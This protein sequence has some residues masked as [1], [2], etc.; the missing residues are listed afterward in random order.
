[1]LVVFQI[2]LPGG[3]AYGDH[4]IVGKTERS[5]GVRAACCRFLSRKLACGIW[6]FYI[7][8]HVGDKAVYTQVDRLS[9]TSE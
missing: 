5:F 3:G 9:P 4:S 1:M 2:N 7:S 8:V 6:S